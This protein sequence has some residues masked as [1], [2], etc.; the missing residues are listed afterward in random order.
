MVRT[1]VQLT[2]RQLR[3]LRQRSTATGRSIA[4]LIRQG[5]ELYVVS[6]HRPDRDEQIER[7][8]GVAGKFSSGSASGS[9]EHDRH[10]AEAWRR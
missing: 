9:Q 4:D 6:Q 10:L 2:E 8:L 1:Q 3:A 5:V 7:A